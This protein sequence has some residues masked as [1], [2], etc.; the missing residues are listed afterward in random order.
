MLAI[1]LRP[2][3]PACEQLAVLMPVGVI[4]LRRNPP[5]DFALSG[6][7]SEGGR[8]LVAFYDEP[9]TAHHQV[10]RDGVHHGFW[11]FRRYGAFERAT[12]GRNMAKLFSFE[13]EGVKSYGS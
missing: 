6:K 11:R 8:P 5:G 1:L 12:R 10:G 13:G 9:L 2:F 3:G 4:E 7:N